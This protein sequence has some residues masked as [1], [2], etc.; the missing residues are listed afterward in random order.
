MG[1]FTLT[2]ATQLIAEFAHRLDRLGGSTVADL[3]TP[4]GHYTID[5]ASLE[6]RDAIRRGF[7]ARAGRG[8][9]TSRHVTTDVRIESRDDNRVTVTS[10]ML[11]W[12]ADGHAPIL[13]TAPMAVI[14]VADVITRQPDATWLFARRTLTSIFRDERGTVTP[15]STGRGPGN[16]EGTIS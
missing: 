12:A 16:P 10:V 11:L 3:F 8:P 4:D 14:D 7:A 5:G 2:S 9:R 1:D 13:G 15:M 6:G